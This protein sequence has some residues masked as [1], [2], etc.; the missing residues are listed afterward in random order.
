MNKRQ[1]LFRR[2]VRNCPEGQLLPKWA[3]F[4]HWL[5]FPLRSIRW[6]LERREGFQ[7][8]RLAWRIR[9]RYFL[10]ETFSILA[11]CEDGAMFKVK[12]TKSGETEYVSIR[13]VKP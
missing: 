10:D 6:T 12:K 13:M 7:I 8:D 11:R 1:K 4:I 3:I 5:L 9:G 2:I